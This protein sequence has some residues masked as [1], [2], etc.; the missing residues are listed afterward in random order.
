MIVDRVSIEKFRGF[1]KQIFSLGK[2]VTFIAG[3]NGTQKS[4]L[5]G[6]LTQTFT[7]PTDHPFTKEK[8][9][10]G[11]TFRSSFRDKFKLSPA[12]DLPGEHEWSLFFYNKELHPDLDNQGG[13][14]VESIPRSSEKGEVVRFWQKGKRNKGSGYV[15]LPVIYLSLKR[16]IPI[17]EAG[18]LKE[19][20]INLTT[21]E[22]TW[23]SENY[24]KILISRD[25][26][27][28]LNYLTNAQKTIFGVTSDNYDWHSNSAG[29]DNLS[30]ILLAVL[31]FKRLKDKYPNE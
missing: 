1:K 20:N 21:S 16:L 15:N 3:Q 30:R 27:S 5:L 8:P 28:E 23:F 31:S 12:L 24:N 19:K 29:Q 6:I 2:R 9:L 10:S 18:S 14:T 17:A 26:V 22:N 4:T 7:I 13:F 11:G 25:N